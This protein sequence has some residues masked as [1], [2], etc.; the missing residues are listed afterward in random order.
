[1]ELM[2]ITPGEDWQAAENK[3]VYTAESLSTEGFIHCSTRAQILATANRFYHARRGLVLLVIDSEKL[4]API[5]FENLEGGSIQ[6]PHIY[7][8]LNLDAVVG[9]IPFEPGPDGTFS[10]PG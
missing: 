9:V 4:T 1:M 8:P 10:L 3:G 2:H 5:R 7:G 6:F